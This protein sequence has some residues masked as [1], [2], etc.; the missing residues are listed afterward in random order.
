VCLEKHPARNI[1][2][3]PSGALDFAP[4]EYGGTLSVLTE[5]TENA[6]TAR[7]ESHEADIGSARP[8]MRESPLPG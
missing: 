1:H 4:R 8:S 2:G 5:C 6:R 3:E 7:V